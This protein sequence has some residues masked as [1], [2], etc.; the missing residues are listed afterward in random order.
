MTSDLQDR[1]RVM[2]QKGQGRAPAETPIAAPAPV[3]RPQQLPIWANDVRGLP[4]SLARSAL[5]SVSNR[6]AARRKFD[7]ETVN[8]VD[9]IAITYTGEELRQDDEDVFLQITHMCRL[10]PLGNSVQ[11]TG[12]GLLKAL[13]VTAGTANYRRV[14]R[15]LERLQGARVRLSRGGQ[16]ETGKV[17]DVF[18]G[19]LIASFSRREREDSLSTKWS[20]LLDPTILRLFGP[21]DYTLLNFDQRLQLSPLGK[22]LHQF[23]HTHRDPFPYKVETLYRL[24]RSESKHLFH[25][26]PRLK[27]SL[28]ELKR[29]GFL[30]RWELRNDTVFVERHPTRAAL[31]APAA[32]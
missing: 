32:V 12:Y 21:D 5:F 15:N 14:V 20:V 17:R 4:N 26:R 1:V 16:D 11:F 19:Q 22:W 7:A 24:C 8:T 3:V 9:G 23:Y 2:A 18:V 6:N 25:F 30:R 29:V 27:V 28:E 10:Q 31:L 13:G